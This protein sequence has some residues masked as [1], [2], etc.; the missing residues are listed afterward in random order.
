MFSRLLNQ[1]VSLS[2]PM[3]TIKKVQNIM[4]V[5]YCI[6]KTRLK[7]SVVKTWIDWG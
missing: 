4:F 7:I 2:L 1:Q 3:S 5:Q 6:W